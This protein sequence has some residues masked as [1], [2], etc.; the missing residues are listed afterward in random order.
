MQKRPELR[1]EA[2]RQGHAAQEHPGPRRSDPSDASIAGA[3][4]EHAAQ[5]PESW[6]RINVGGVNES[7][8]RAREPY[9][10]GTG[11]RKSSVARVRLY[12]ERHRLHHHQRPRHR[13]LLRPGDPE[14]HRP[15][16]PGHHRH[17]RARWT[18]SPPSPAAASPARPAP[19]VT[20]CPAPCCWSTP[21]SVPP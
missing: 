5:K 9:F 1:H 8:I 15:S 19:S 3:E 4:H 6:T 14:A 12:A 11:R 13:R 21:S 16:A 18:S 7:C 17:G 20:A 10:Y 2:G